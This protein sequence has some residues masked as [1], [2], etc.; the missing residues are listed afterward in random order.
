MGWKNG[1][2]CSRPCAPYQ[3][4][5]GTP[6]I[7]QDQSRPKAQQPW[8]QTPSSEMTQTKSGPIAKR[9]QNAQQLQNQ[10]QSAEM[11]QQ[12]S[13]PIAKEVQK[14]QTSSNR[15]TRDQTNSKEP[16]PSVSQWRQSARINKQ[17][18]QHQSS[19]QPPI[20]QHQGRMYIR[21]IRIV[22][23][24]SPAPTS[25]SLPLFTPS[26]KIFITPLLPDNDNDSTQ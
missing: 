19:L 3:E 24:L 5:L 25:M 15:D 8:N 23:D 21:T 12:K 10:N 6:E 2:S 14:G 13:G 7:E 16:S 4:G 1:T 18:P 26:P 9:A 22:D 17:T 20:T 11:T